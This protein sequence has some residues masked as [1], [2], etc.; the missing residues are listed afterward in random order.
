MEEKTRKQLLCN[1]VKHIASNVLVSSSNISEFY[2]YP[3]SNLLIHNLTWRKTYFSQNLVESSR[4]LEIN[5]RNRFAR[6]SR[7][8][9]DCQDFERSKL[10]C[11]LMFFSSRALVQFSSLNCKILIEMIQFD[12]PYASYFTQFNHSLWTSKTHLLPTEQKNP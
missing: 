8:S 2:Q 9:V 3:Y 10:P 7:F 11:F 4:R 6:F 5:I 12:L 1:T